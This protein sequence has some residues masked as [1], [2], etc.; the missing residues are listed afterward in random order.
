[1]IL[2]CFENNDCYSEL[3]SFIFKATHNFSLTNLINHFNFAGS[4]CC[5]RV[6]VYFQIA[7]ALR[8]P[9]ASICLS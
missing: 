9:N 4:V 7:L 3:I 6:T 1:M 8:N 2:L 5:R